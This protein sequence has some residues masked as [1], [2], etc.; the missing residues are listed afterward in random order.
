MRI[1]ADDYDS[2]YIGFTIPSN[3]TSTDNVMVKI[4]NDNYLVRTIAPY[5]YHDLPIA[6]ASGRL[7]IVTIGDNLTIDSSG[8]L[9]STGGGL[10]ATVT[11]GTT[12]TGEAGTNAS[13][14]NSGTAQS[15]VLNFVIPKGANGSNGSDG[16]D[17][18]DGREIELQV[19]DTYIQW[20]YI[21]DTTW[22]N[23]I[24]LS[25]LK[26][27]KGD[28]GI[29]GETGA[30]NT[31]TIGT[32]TKGDNAEATITGTS[33]NQVL[34]L[35]LPKGD[36]GEQGIQGKDGNSGVYIGT[37]EPTDS[38]INVWIDEDGLSEDYDGLPVGSVID[39]D[40]DTVPTG[41]EEIKDTQ[42]LWTNPNPTTAI[43][44]STNIT[45]LNDDYDVLE[46]FYRLTTSKNFIMSAKI[47]KG[48]DSRLIA[49]RQEGTGLYRE[50]IYNSDTSYTLNI[51]SA[52][53]VQCIPL[54]IVGYK[55]GLFS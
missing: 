24:A 10:A 15:A 51:G 37:E 8:R 44:S 19:T 28:Q 46:I 31:L 30:S 23:L 32:V 27:A 42:I 50:L 33:P 18:T 9:S 48:W 20:R 13:V 40:G 34:N 55:T 11:V 54:Y 39:Y 43:S 21:G 29:Q 12:T 25:E 38:S 52:E 26:G 7:G 5:K 47:L 49:I 3:L 1:R 41:Y 17:G 16:A 4:E 36:Q 53:S 6:N 45:L 22:Y 14:T 35:V 2:E